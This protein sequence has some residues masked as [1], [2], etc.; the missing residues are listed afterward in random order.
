M[1]ELIELL[2]D[3]C[4]ALSDTISSQERGKTSLFHLIIFEP[5]RTVFDELP[6]LLLSHGHG[7][8][9]NLSS[10]NTGSV[11]ELKNEMYLCSHLANLCILYLEKEKGEIDVY[12]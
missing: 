7:N 6:I 2:S 10:L 5:K 3:S 4:W 8:S 11:E 1:L 12:D 9:N